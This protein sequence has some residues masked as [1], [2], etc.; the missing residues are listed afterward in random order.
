MCLLKLNQ[1]IDTVGS[2]NLL[3]LIFSNLSDLRI[4]LVDPGL[5][6]PVNYH[7]PLIFNIY[8]PFVTCTQNYVYS[9]RKFSS[10]DYALLY[11]T[12]SNFVWSCVYG[13]TSVDSAVSCFSAVVQDAMEHEIPRGIINT[14]LKLSHWYSSSL[15]YYIRKK[16]YFTDVPKKKKK[17]IR[18][19]LPKIFYL[20]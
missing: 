3:D 12:P 17:E 2:S 10:V 9:Y 15:S 6:K 5:M 1:C 16:N 19:S 4:T 14:N 11:N 20:S 8:L 7:H 13:T 18:L